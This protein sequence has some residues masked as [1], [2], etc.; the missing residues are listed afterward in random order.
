MYILVCQVNG[1]N[2][3]NAFWLAEIQAMIS[4]DNPVQLQDG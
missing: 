1:F 2:L 4:C 3:K